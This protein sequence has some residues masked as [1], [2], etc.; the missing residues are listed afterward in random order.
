MYSVATR[1][2]NGP[3]SEIFEPTDSLTEEVALD[4]LRTFVRVLQ[5]SSSDGTDDVID[6]VIQTICA[7]SLEA[8]GKPEKAQAKAGIKA[9]CTFVD[10]SCMSAFAF[11]MVD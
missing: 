6:A 2:I 7:D 4:T 10:V 5:P 8:I 3:C 11:L 9:L 1:C